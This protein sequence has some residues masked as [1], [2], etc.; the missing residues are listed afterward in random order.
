MSEKI[1]KK[2]IVDIISEFVK[3]N[4]QY[5]N[6]EMDQ[7]SETFF[8]KLH[9]KSNTRQRKIPEDEFRCSCMTVKNERC[10]NKILENNKVCLIHFKQANKKKD[11]GDNEDLD[12]LFS[13]KKDNSTIEYGRIFTS[14]CVDNEDE[15]IIVKTREIKKKKEKKKIPA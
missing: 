4:I 9:L 11:E 3:F 13:Y 7:L 6:M 2:I 8:S 15:D 1:I 14:V 5:P 10:R 12:K